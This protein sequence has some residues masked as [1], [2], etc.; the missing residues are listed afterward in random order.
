MD[1]DD[2]IH[3]QQDIIQSWEKINSAIFKHIDRPWR[4]YAM[5]NNSDRK[6]Q[7]LHDIIYM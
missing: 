3:I 5:A 6:S 7:R 4:H 1:K 2:V